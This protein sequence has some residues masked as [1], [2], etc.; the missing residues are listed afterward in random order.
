MIVRLWTG[1][2]HRG[3]E[4]EYLAHLR[5][6]VIP[7]IRALPGARGVRV[8]RGVEPDDAEFVVMTYWADLEAV[9]GFAGADARV[10]VVPPEAQALL[11]RFDREAQ[12]FEVALDEEAFA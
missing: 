5:E 7:E 1:T 9:K 11:A 12:H 8:L 10:A 2:A 6:A 3:E 4:A